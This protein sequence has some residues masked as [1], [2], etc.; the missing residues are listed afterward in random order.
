MFNFK[1]QLLIICCLFTLLMLM[2][3]PSTI[4]ACSSRSVP[5]PRPFSIAAPTTTKMPPS[6]TSTT[7]ITSTTTTTS[8]STLA[9]I[10]A[11]T[12]ATTTTTTT[13]LRPNITFPTFKCSADYH[14]WYCLN[15]AT[16]F[17]VKIGGSIMHNCECAI[18]FMGP[19]C[20]YK[21]LD[22]SYQPKLPRP[23]LEQ[24]SIASGI[25]CILLILLF[26]CLVLYLRYDHK[27]AVASASKKLIFYDENVYGEAINN[28]RYC[29]EKRYCS[30]LAME[31]DN[32]YLLISEE[33]VEDEKENNSCLHQ[34][35]EAFP[36]VY[37]ENTKCF[38]TDICDP[39]I[40]CNGDNS[41]TWNVCL[42][43][44][45]SLDISFKN[46]IYTEIFNLL[47]YEK[48]FRLSNETSIHFQ[49]LEKINQTAV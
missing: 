1:F 32:K 12:T 21:E 27:V 31:N 11:S 33:K 15:E 30:T 25:T 7:T 18:G 26:I 13:T 34:H 49:S 4:L 48:L 43:L 40:F 42:K 9:T 37:A 8:T 35:I 23:I 41:K 17:A 46:K 10:S 20:E 19:R 29:L 5:K 16:C 36:M 38:S 6:T 39:N 44:F 45:S 47:Y 28:C 3:W 14:K 24:A 2:C 22:G